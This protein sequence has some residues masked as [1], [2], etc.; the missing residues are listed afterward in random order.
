MR[1]VNLIPAEQR[2]GASVGAGRSQGAAYAVLALVAGLAVMAVLY[3]IA[4]HQVTSGT[5]E[6]AAITAQA[7]QAKSASTKLAPYA[8]FVTAQEQR[9]QE[10]AQVVDSRFD[11]AHVFHEFGRVIPAS[12]SID[13]LSG[14]ISSPTTSSGGSSSSTTSASTSSASSSTTAVGATP[15]G[16]VPS[17]T[18]SGCATSQASVAL[19]LTRLRLIDGVSEVTLGSST[20]T[21]TSGA[22][23]SGG[24][25]PGGPAYT[26]N[27]IFDPI[28]ASPASKTGSSTSVV[29]AGAGPSSGTTVAAVDPKGVPTK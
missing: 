19:L 13:S 27:V 14:Q 20:K 3:G 12:V 11:W 16:S 24:C 1:A 9:S 28:P 10:V 29:V 7:E 21:S 23:A 8:S 26:A 6:A 15:A 22:A 2:G 4:S 25:P 18:V 5:S 17:F